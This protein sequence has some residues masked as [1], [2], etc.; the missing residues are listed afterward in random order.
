MSSFTIAAL[1]GSHLVDTSTVSSHAR[2]NLASQPAQSEPSPSNNSK[3]PP[4]SLTHFPHPIPSI[5]HRRLTA[6]ERASRQ[7]K[8]EA[9]LVAKREWKRSHVRPREKQER[10]A[11]QAVGK[12]KTPNAFLLYRRDRVDEIVKENKVF[13]NAAEASKRV[14]ENWKNE[15]ESVR[16]LYKEKAEL[17]R[18]KA[19]LTPPL[20]DTP[21]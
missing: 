6:E 18:M 16:Q 13:L 1:Y 4:S 17:L 19:I 12:A 7:S 8:K 3:N 15:P 14:S 2:N 10:A 21:L 11:L 20:S 5:P 9:K